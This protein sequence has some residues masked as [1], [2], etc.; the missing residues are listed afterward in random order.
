MKSWHHFA[1]KLVM[2]AFFSATATG[3]R[4][5]GV[6][7]IQLEAC[8]PYRVLNV[9][10]LMSET[11]NLINDAVNIADELIEVSQTPSSAPTPKFSSPNRH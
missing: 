10:D 9:T 2:S 3:G 4:R 1:D 6:V 11:G 8:A 5:R 7:G